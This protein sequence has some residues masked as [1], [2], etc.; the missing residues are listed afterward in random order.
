QKRAAVKIRRL[1]SALGSLDESFQYFAHSTFD[2]RTAFPPLAGFRLQ[3]YLE[4]VSDGISEHL[5]KRNPRQ[6]PLRMHGGDLAWAL[7]QPDG[8]ATTRAFAY[9]IRK[10][11]RA[12][13]AEIT[14]NETE[15]KAALREVRAGDLVILAPSHR[16]YLDFLITSLLCFAHPG[17]G[18]KLPRVAA[19][20]DFAQI[21]IIGKLLGAAGAFY[22]KRGVGAPDPGLTKQIADLV[23][24]GQSLEFYAEGTRSRSRRFLTPKRGILRAL[25]QAGRPAIVLPLSISYDRIAEEAGFLREL[26]FGVKHKSGLNPL[27]KWTQK[28]IRGD[29][30]LGRIHI[31][32]GAPLR[33]EADSDIK[34]VSHRIVAEL[35]RHAA[36]SSFHIRVFCDAHAASGI[37]AAGLRSAIIRR[38]GM[39]IESKLDGEEKVP[40]VLRRTYDGQWMHLFYADARRRAPDNIA[41]KS[42]IRRNGFWFPEALQFVDHL[43]DAVVEALFEP[44]CRDYERVAAEVE[45][46]PLDG[47]I[48]AHQIV[49][50]LD[51]AFL[52]DVED[53]LAD[54]AE[55]EI[56]GQERDSYHWANG[57]RD[58]S[59][60]RNDC[61]WDGG[62]LHFDRILS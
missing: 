26:E 53:A 39:I 16:S 12:A 37:D 13:G 1:A 25:R 56:L 24:S 8:N 52:G 47:S 17:L 54:L 15:I 51:D 7:R 5:L 43:T 59:E 44:V 3:C 4:T 23:D 22:I 28:L 55:R 9:V 50:R 46:L 61:A 2:F 11:L 35:Q 62:A 20:D 41:V 45:K 21:P 19:T 36:V 58:L 18:L 6:A 57:V 29:V 14:F 30:K 60:Y 34:K 10:A 31:R 40:A 42:H 49:A 32:A 38:G 48:T 33:I 27:L